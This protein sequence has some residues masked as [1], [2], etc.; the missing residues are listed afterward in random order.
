MGMVLGIT[1][2]MMEERG[3]LELK[4]EGEETEEGWRGW[5][6][7]GTYIKFQVYTRLRIRFAA[8]RPTLL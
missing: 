7:P 4:V 5:Y 6:T 3:G 2:A 8:K 1:A